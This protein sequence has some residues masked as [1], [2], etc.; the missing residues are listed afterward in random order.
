[1]SGIIT[2]GI[3]PGS[4]LTVFL[5]GGLT[6]PVVVVATPLSRTLVVEAEDRVVV[7][8]LEDRAIRVE[9]EDRIIWEEQVIKKLP[10]DI[11][12]VLDF[13]VNLR[14][15]TNSI[16]GAKSDWLEAGE[17]ITAYSA[18]ASNG[19]TVDD[20][21]ESSGVITVWLS[22][23]DSGMTSLVTVKFS[24]SLGRTGRRSFM[25]EQKLR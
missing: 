1:M 8:E 14:P 21:D 10:M 7:V 20:V 23:L 11:E 16:E 18:S 22:G 17:T 19:V 2:Q 3:G 12:E 13:E 24:T 4:S 25:V 5:T 6:V 15:L 9:W